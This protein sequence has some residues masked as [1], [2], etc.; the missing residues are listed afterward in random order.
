MRI[1]SKFVDYYDTVQG[2]GG[3][4]ELHYIRNQREIGTIGNLKGKSF[5]FSNL[6]PNRLNLN[7]RATR[8]N[9]NYISSTDLIV[10]RVLFCGKLYQYVTIENCYDKSK[11]IHINS[12]SKLRDVLLNDGRFQYE[13]EEAVLK[14]LARINK[15]F[16]RGTRGYKGS[17]REFHERFKKARS[18]IE[19][20]FTPPLE[21]SPDI[22]FE[23]GTP[24]FSCDESRGYDRRRLNESYILADSNLRE[25]NFQFVMDPF[26]VF[27][28]IEMFIGGV[29]GEAH[30]PIVQIS[31]A[32]MKVAK[33]FGHKYAFKKEP[34]KRKLNGFEN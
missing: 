16:I 28:E 6:I 10:R 26:T 11:A 4:D 23:Y 15:T 2:V 8:K 3:S 27:Q 12:Y 1:K 21:V 5:D 34:T 25:L 33:G 30:P 29:L 9:E 13:D 24:I 7:V 20:L 14:E 22:F 19:E 32:D 31:D 17:R 18:S